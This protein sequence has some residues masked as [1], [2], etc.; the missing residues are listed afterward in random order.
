MPSVACTGEPASS[1]A[2][3]PTCHCLARN[4]SGSRT[5]AWR[6]RASVASRGCGSSRVQVVTDGISRASSTSTEARD[7][8]VIDDELLSEGRRGRSR[9]EVERE[10]EGGQDLPHLREAREID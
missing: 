8:V 9:L 5:C 7:V 3:S 4:Q 2:N 6:E 1:P 10:V